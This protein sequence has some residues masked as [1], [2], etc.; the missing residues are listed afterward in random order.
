MSRIAII[1]NAG[2]GKSTLAR[3]LAASHGLGHVEID[4]LLW[5]EGWTLT[6]TEIYEREH[7]DIIHSD[8]W[9][10]DG[11]GRRES[12]PYRLARAT[13]IILIDMPVW[14]HFWLAAER[15]VA[16]ASGQ[17][18]HAPG[19][20]AE[21]PPT[22]ALFQ[23]IWDVEHTWMPDIRTLCTAAEHDGTSVVRLTDIAQLDD[24]IGRL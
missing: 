3:R 12:I 9:I 1:G 22:K 21:M 20:I 19:G 18:Q 15:Q 23:T 17:L 14:M 10:I 6:S 2:G 13:Q 5:Q 11:L 24:F 16:W 8:G 4:R 7:T